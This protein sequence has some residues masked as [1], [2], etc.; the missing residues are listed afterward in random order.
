M[1]C[2]LGK[3]GSVRSVD[4]AA[5]AVDEQPTLFG[6][7]IFAHLAQRAALGAYA[8]HEEEV[9]G[10]EL[11]HVCEHLALCGSH[12][13]HHV[14]LVAPFLRLCE[15]LLKQACALFVGCELEV[16]A[17]L[18]ACEGEQHHP[19]VLVAQE[20]RHAVLAHVGCHGKR[21]DVILL[22]EGACIHGACVAYVAAL[23]IGYDEVVGIVLLK[24]GHGLLEGHDALHAEG[25]VEGQVGL[26]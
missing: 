20:G 22:E 15:H 3:V 17:A 8:R 11:A 2:H 21:V 1:C 26:V 16:V 5:R 7:G 18:V 10:N 23:G 14:V 13:I 24:I 4:D 6:H 12:N 19:L 9:V 25:L